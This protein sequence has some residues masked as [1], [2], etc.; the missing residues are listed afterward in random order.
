MVVV[1]N[2]HIGRRLLYRRQRMRRAQQGK[3][4]GQRRSSFSG[5]GSPSR[6]FIGREVYVA[7]LIGWNVSHPESVARKPGRG[8]GKV[9]APK[10]S[11]RIAP[12]GTATSTTPFG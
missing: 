4:R 10:S 6:L 11:R 12:Q 5:N 8:L 9:A 1:T 7:I 2:L 3:R